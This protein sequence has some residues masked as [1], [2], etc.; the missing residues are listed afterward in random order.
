MLRE[1]YQGVSRF[2]KGEENFVRDDLPDIEDRLDG[3]ITDKG[4]HAFLRHEKSAEHG[5]VLAVY[6]G[7]RR[8]PE[9][10]KVDTIE[11]VFKTHRGDTYLTALTLYKKY[12]HEPNAQY[13]P[14]PQ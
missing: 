7:A 5:L 6:F 8:E 3:I 10:I 2:L 9:R 11:K 12:L 13:D 1:I 14:S 4:R